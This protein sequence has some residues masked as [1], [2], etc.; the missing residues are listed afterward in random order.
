MVCI[1]RSYA[2][3]L[4]HSFI[5]FLLYLS[6]SCVC[7]RAREIYPGCFWAIAFD[8][9]YPFECDTLALSSHDCVHLGWERVQVT[10]KLFCCCI[11]DFLFL[12]GKRGIF[13]TNEGC[14][15][16]TGNVIVQVLGLVILRVKE[17]MLERFLSSYFRY[18]PSINCCFQTL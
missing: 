12:N 6:S 9:T 3:L 15:K 8:T 7:S 13:T 17:P 16:L 1:R 11:V 2:L 10:R 4:F 18:L 5:R 14:V